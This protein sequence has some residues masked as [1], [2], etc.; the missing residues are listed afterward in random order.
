MSR[1]VIAY[2][3][4]AVSELLRIVL[5]LHGHV[6]V[7]HEDV[8]VRES[9]VDALIV[10]PTWP[11]GLACAHEL[12]RSY[13]DIPIVCISVRSPTQEA[14]ALRPVSYLTMPFRL[15]DL[16]LAVRSALGH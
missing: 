3:Q 8:G 14:Q 2:P 13:P 1:I 11:T 15:A 16:E 7:D 9:D 5:D 10:D 12:R 6:S 4:G